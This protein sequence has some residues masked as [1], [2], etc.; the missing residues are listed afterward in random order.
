[1][2]TETKYIHNLFSAKI[3]LLFVLLVITDMQNIKIIPRIGSDERE[4]R[5][6]RVINSAGHRPAEQMPT[7]TKPQRA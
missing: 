7:K 3:Q 6:K 1:M 5:C 4:Q 2:S